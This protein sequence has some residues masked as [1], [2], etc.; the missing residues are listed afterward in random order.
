MQQLIDA[1]L[2]C[3][4]SAQLLRRMQADLRLYLEKMK[5]LLCKA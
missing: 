5:R 2:A 4:S 1:D 3:S